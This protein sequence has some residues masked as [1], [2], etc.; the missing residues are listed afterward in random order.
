M[1][2]EH[3]VVYG[4]P[5]IATAIQLY[6]H[7]HYT[8][9]KGSELIAEFIGIKVH[10]NHPIAKLSPLVSFLDRQF[11]K[12]IDGSI[13]VES[14]LNSPVQLVLYVL[15]S[16][17]PTKSL[18][19][20]FN[21]DSE[22]PIGA[23]M[24]SSASMIAAAVV[25]VEAIKKTSSSSEQR[26]QLVKH[27]ERLQ[28]GKG[29]LI[30]AATVILGG[31]VQVQQ[32]SVKQLPLKLNQHWYWLFTGTPQCS[33]GECVSYVAQQH[34]SDTQLWDEFAAV[35]EQMTAQLTNNADPSEAIVANQTLLEHI[36]VVSE[37]TK[38]II[39]QLKARGAVAKVAG[40]GAYIG[41]SSGLL[42][43]YAENISPEQLFAGYNMK[44]GVLKQDLKGAR[45]I[46]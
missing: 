26:Y 12:F 14:I 19:A 16:Q 35:T 11:Q 1:S 33:T 20:H 5:A 37:R 18:S 41:D 25:L 45:I 7:I 40:A 2:G 23:G 29:S 27:C 17:L 43:V 9:V 22:L 15:A 3:S 36:G 42:L 30:D 10:S 31:V 24:G 34:R 6:S 32:L 21:G 4:A 44:W 13:K 39:Q 28:H 8:P 46:V 38:G